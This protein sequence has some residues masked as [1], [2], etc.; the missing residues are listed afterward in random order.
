MFHSGLDMFVD[1]PRSRDVQ[2]NE[3]YQKYKSQ[4]KCITKV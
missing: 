2:P 1:Y 4:R 3:M